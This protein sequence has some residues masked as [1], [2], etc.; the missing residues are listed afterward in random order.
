MVVIAVEL[1]GRRIVVMAESI[2]RA[3]ED[4]N[5]RY[6]GSEARVVFPIDPEDFFGGAPDS[7]LESLPR[8][9]RGRQARR[10]RPVEDGWRNGFSGNANGRKHQER[11]PGGTGDPRPVE[12][13][14]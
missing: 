13:L 14:P 6:P 9:P 3:V 5:S 1:D 2:V 12:G 8:E 10:A 7:S 4:V 11:R